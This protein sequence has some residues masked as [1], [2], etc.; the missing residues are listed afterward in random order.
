MKICHDKWLLLTEELAKGA[1]GINFNDNLRCRN[2][3]ADLKAEI[4]RTEFFDEAAGEALGL[5]E[6]ILEKYVA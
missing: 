4:D 1:K 5:N 3:W 2:A 6:G